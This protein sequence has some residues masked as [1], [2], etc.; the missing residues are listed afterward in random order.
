MLSPEDLYDYQKEAVMHGLYR[1]DV[2]YWLGL[3]LGKTVIALTVAVD[4]MRAGQVNK[5]LVLGPLRVIQ[6]VWAAEARKWEHLKHLRFSLVHGSQNERR[7]A[8]FAKADVFLV[9]YDNLNWLAEDLDHYFIGRGN[10]LPWEMCIYD[11][12]TRCKNSTSV[13]INGGKRDI[14][15][16]RTGREST[17]TRVG[18]RKCI[19]QFQ[20]RLGLTGSPAANGYLDLHGQFLVVDGG[21]RLGPR[22]TKFREDYFS[23]AWDGYTYTVTDAGRECI[24]SRIADVTLKMD[25]RDYRHDLPEAVEKDVFVELPAKARKAYKDMENSMF[26]ELEDGSNVEVFSGSAAATKTLQIANGAAYVNDSPD[27]REEADGVDLSGREWSKIHEAKMEALEGVVE[28][29]NGQPVLVAYSF[30]TDAARIQKKFP[31]AVNLTSAPS[32]QTEEIIQRWRNG[33]IQMLVGHPASMGHGIDGLQEAGSI[34]V[35]FG[36]NWSLELYMQM[37]ARINR[38]GQ[39]RPVS[40]IRILA[41]DTIDEAVVAALANK[42][43]DE[44][45]LKDAIYA[46]LKSEPKEVSFL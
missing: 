16:P 42:A 10:P 9:N 15:D 27:P 21:Q 11:E 38:P 36:V 17:I 14:T 1:Q 19:D 30:K 24:E 18:W 4:R 34:V 31:R 29:A 12:V 28:D 22:K 45:A 26:A 8:L 43:T 6:S 13:R 33:D 32:G 20:Y 44:A 5:V 46:Y 25:T 37:N 41:K 23:Q 3:G 35:W 2:M 39:R 40:I 7:R